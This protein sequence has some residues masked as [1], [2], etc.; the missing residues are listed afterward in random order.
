MLRLSR[1]VSFHFRAHQSSA[2]TGP[3]RVHAAEGSRGPMAKKL[4]KFC[5]AAA[6]CRKWYPVMQTKTPE[7]ISDPF[8]LRVRVRVHVHI[9]SFNIY[10]PIAGCKRQATDLLARDLNQLIPITSARMQRLKHNA[11]HPNINKK[12]DYKRKT[13]KSSRKLFGVLIVTK[14]K[15]RN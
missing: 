12:E 6:R 3:S 1:G 8:H 4:L 9:F 13:E 10:Y 11:Q 15:K 7:S 2:L 5:R 14:K